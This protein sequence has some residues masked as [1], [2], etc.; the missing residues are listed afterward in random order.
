[1]DNQKIISSPSH[2]LESYPG[3]RTRLLSSGTPGKGPVLYW[4]EREQR[5]RDN[6]TL[7]AAQSH[8]M[9][10]NRN[11][12]IIFVVHNYGTEQQERHYRFVLQG[13]LETIDEASRYG[14]PFSVIVGDPVKEVINICNT[15]KCFALFTDLNPLRHISEAKKLICKELSIPVFETDARN[16]IPCFAVSPKQ[17]YSAHTLRLKHNRLIDD[18]HGPLPKIKKTE[19]SKPNQYPD[20]KK[21]LKDLHLDSKGNMDHPF[22]PGAK[23]AKRMLKLFLTKKIR[24]YAALDR[25]P[26]L[27]VISNLSPYIHFG[28]I[29][30]HRILSELIKT[31]ISDDNSEKFYD[32]LV[33]RRELS[34]NFVF[35]NN[36]YDNYN[37]IPD[38]GKRTLLA[39]RMDPRDY[40]YRFEQFEAAATHD[41]L[42]NA[43]QKQMITTSKMHCYLRM[44]WAKKILEWSASPEE[45]FNTAITLNDRYSL[46]GEDPNGYAGVAWSIGGL[47]DRPWSERPVFGYV[48]FMNLAGCKRKFNV[49]QFV[50]RFTQS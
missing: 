5:I 18:Y 39:H 42:W 43:A 30:T 23:E 44:Y 2:S 48:R 35:Y 6:H 3:H 4:M 38:W 45:A 9:L 47:H 40:N 8:A 29:G 24:N 28:Q 34:E 13:I 12:E 32:Q 19:L 15:K 46:D 41:E 26:N 37:G 25:D 14:L 21:I 50:K 31:E 49:D 11:L 27:D 36:N 7:E 1:M 16:I 10:H 17:E 22:I 20:I 33:I